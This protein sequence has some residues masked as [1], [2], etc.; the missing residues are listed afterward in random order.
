MFTRNVIF[1]S[2]ACGFGF[3]AAF[4]FTMWVVGSPA[5]DLTERPASDIGQDRLRVAPDAELIRWFLF[6]DGEVGG[7]V[8]SSVPAELVGLSSTELADSHSYWRLVSFAPHRVV[9]EE[10]CPGL[11]GGFV[12]SE[13]GT[14]LVYAGA[15]DG[16][17]RQTTTL[18]FDMDHVSPLHAAELARGVPFSSESELSLILEGLAAP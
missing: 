3:I 17:H 1:F 8:I 13:Q 14:L 12:R 6:E 4:L 10:H 7:P 16:C 11:T 5:V 18:D 15:I 2:L 9:V